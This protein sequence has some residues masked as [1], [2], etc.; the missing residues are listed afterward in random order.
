M[1]LI[2]LCVKKQL[3]QLP[4][5]AVQ[6]VR[7][8]RLLH[9]VL[10]T[11]RL[12]VKRKRVN[13]SLT[14]CQEKITEKNKLCL[15]VPLFIHIV[16]PLFYL[17]LYVSPHITSRNDVLMNFVVCHIKCIFPSVVQPC[18]SHSML[19]RRLSAT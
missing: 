9:S 6:V 11:S 18:A 17:Q 4:V 3:H 8:L 12:F 16:L 10:N 1:L 5:T 19:K 14:S 13:D 15:W 7:Q 2:T